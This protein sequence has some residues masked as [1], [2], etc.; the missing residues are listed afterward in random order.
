[1]VEAKNEMM[2]EIRKIE[3]KYGLFLFRIALSHLIDVGHRNLDSANVA[4]SMVQIMAQGE[5][6][7]ANGSMQIMSPEFLCEV[8]CCA[9]EL[10]R[11][12]PWTLL[13]YIKKHV[14]ISD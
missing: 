2:N 10:A 1:M 3:D 12:S 4:E 7:K 13:K 5:A 6:D 14:H 11:F 8:L 9:A